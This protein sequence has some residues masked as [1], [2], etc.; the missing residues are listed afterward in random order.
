MKTVRTQQPEIHAKAFDHQTAGCVE[1][2]GIKRVSEKL[3]P[4]VCRLAV[5]ALPREEKWKTW[6]WF[7]VLLSGG[8][9]Q[10]HAMVRY[11]TSS[12]LPRIRTSAELVG[13]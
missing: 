9:A 6:I 13:F 2:R 1:S 7:T 12:A 5:R 3:L 4:E 8:I 10:T 11:F